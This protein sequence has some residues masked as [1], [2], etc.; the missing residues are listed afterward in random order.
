MVSSIAIVTSASARHASSAEVTSA[1]STY[2]RSAEVTSAETAHVTS[3]EAASAEAASA[4]AASAEAA[5]TSASAAPAACLCTRRQQRPGK[6]G[7]CQY[8]HR[9]S[10]RHVIFLSADRAI[11]DHRPSRPGQIWPPGSEAL[12]GNFEGGNRS[13]RS[14]WHQQKK[15]D[16]DQ[17]AGSAWVSWSG[18]NALVV[19]VRHSRIRFPSILNSALRAD[20]GRQARTR[21]RNGLSGESGRITTLRVEAS[22]EATA[23]WGISVMPSSAA[24]IWISVRRLVAWKTSL[25][26][27]STIRHACSEW[28]RRQCPSSIR[29]SCSRARLLRSTTL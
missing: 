6:Q 14:H 11:S 17:R 9:S 2:V 18:A 27:G 22:S 29:S 10:S 1:D 4:G 13:S 21:V 15:D 7:A 26:T 3:A 28:L 23:I 5:A 16:A 12:T 25:R 8:H 19:P 24:T 20:V